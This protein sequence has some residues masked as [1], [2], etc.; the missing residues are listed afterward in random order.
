MQ[1]GVLD[2]LT[3]IEQA[4]YEAYLVG[5]CVRDRVMGTEPHDYDI[6]TSALPQEIKG[7]FERVLETGIAHGTVTVLTADGPL[8]ITTYRVDG[9][10]VDHRHPVGVQFTRSLR[11]DLARRDFTVNAMA[12]DRHGAIT[13]LFGGRADIEKKIIRCVGEPA[14]RFEEDALRILRGLRFAARL[15]FAIEEQTALAMEEKKDG[16]KSIAA[17]RIFAELC[18]LLS[19]KYAAEILEKYRSVMAVVLP[20]MGAPAPKPC[21][22]TFGMAAL[23]SAAQDPAA[24]LARLK[25]PNAFKEEVLMLIRNQA[26]SC[27]KTQS[28]LYR[29]A[30]ALGEKDLRKVYAYRGW[31][32]AEMEAFLQQSPC[33]CIK[34]LALDGKDLMALGLEGPAI[35]QTLADLLKK[36]M[37]GLPNEKDS[38]LNAIKNR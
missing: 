12:M 11:E 15:G 4:G 29:L 25:A 2:V 24:P 33:L 32:Q 8:E 5:G 10:Y 14:L 37:E 9:E 7:L 30:V 21:P 19:G 1:K 6:T 35:G 36:V 26:T 31:E 22:P 17:E 27:P 13:D 18:G 3:T 16:L 38:L 34:D 20:E 28:E 23:L